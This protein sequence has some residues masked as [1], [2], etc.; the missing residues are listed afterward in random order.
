[1]AT[2]LVRNN[3]NIHSSRRQIRLLFNK[4]IGLMKVTKRFYGGNRGYEFGEIEVADKLNIWSD[5]YYYKNRC[6]HEI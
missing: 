2:N 1:M 4:Q 6:L 3:K 5:T